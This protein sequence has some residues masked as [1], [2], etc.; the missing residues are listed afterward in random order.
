MAILKNEP[1]HWITSAEE[2]LAIAH[3][4]ELEA[5]RRYRELSQHMAK[6][7][8]GKLAS[9]FDFLARIEDK[10]AQEVDARAQAII[11]KTVDHAKVRWELPENFD[12]EEA[13]SNLLTPYRALAIAVRNEER[14]FAFYTYLAAHAES[15]RVRLLAE[16]SAKDELEHAALLRRERRNAWR[17]EAHGPSTRRPEIQSVADLL[18][19]AA[20]MERSAAAGHRGLAAQLARGG[21]RLTARLFEEA[22]SD[23][24]AMA[25]DVESRLGRKAELADIPSEAR[26]VREGL[27][28]LEATFERYSMIAERATDEA[29]MNEAQGLAERALRRLTYAQGSIDNTLM[30]ARSDGG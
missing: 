15:D 21:D 22:A 5:G 13:R 18:A 4:M 28:L 8:E 19:D 3:A 2:L 17:E 23:E 20:K 25:E 10:H 12:E 16:E 27:G 6:Q 26:S 24:E 11:G 29:V 7:G 1:P 9:L 30:H 14:A